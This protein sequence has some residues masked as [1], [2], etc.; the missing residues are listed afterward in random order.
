MQKLEIQEKIV[1]PD[2]TAEPGFKRYTFLLY[3]AVIGTIFDIFFYNK[4][5]GISYPVFITVI[6]LLFTAVFIGNLKKLNRRAWLLPIPILLLSLTFFIYSNQVL[7]TLNYL[8]IP[9]L[10]LMFFFIAAKVNRYDWSDIRFISDIARRVF[11][12]FRFI[13]RP[14]IE[15]SGAASSGADNSG[16]KAKSRTLTRVLIGLLISIPLIAVI[17]WLL[18]SADIVFKNY[19]TNIPLLKIFKH[20]IVI[21]AVTVYAACFA[22][23]LIKAFNERKE[24]APE[25]KQWKLFLDPVVLLTILVLINAI[26]AVFSFVQFAYLFGGKTFV[27]PSSFTYS[28]YARRGFAELVVVSIINFALLVFGITFVKK[29]SRKSFIAVKLL[30]SLLVISTFVILVSAFYRMVV[31]ENAY[32]FTYLRIFVQAFMVMVFFLFVIN[33]IYIWYFKLP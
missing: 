7:R 26:Y 6:F 33:I 8:L 31:Y 17:L 18:S 12:P 5:M 23:A 13:H 4:T 1:E 16:G 2:K 21:A 14:F 11:V 10:M 27:M 22:W 19:F 29:E 9:V 24:F 15:L 3:G 28:E 20:F 32:G 30:M 25:K